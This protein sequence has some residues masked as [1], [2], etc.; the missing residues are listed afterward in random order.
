MQTTFTATPDGG[1]TYT[2]TLTPQESAALYLDGPVMF[3]WATDWMAAVA[4][5]RTT[6][7]DAPPSRWAP[8]L[9]T[10]AA[11]LAPRVDG[12]LDALVRAH[13]DAGAS[14]GQTANAMDTARSTAQHRRQTLGR[15]DPSVWE[16]WATGHPDTT[17]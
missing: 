7:D 16:N 10:L 2:V 8:L 17:H 1:A 3:D 12:T 6:P 14:H 15:T 11:Q 4:A 13:M 9:H 5:L